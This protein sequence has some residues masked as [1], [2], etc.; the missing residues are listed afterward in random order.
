MACSS[1]GGNSSNKRSVVNT[2]TTNRTALIDLIPQE[3]Q[4]K[5]VYIGGSYTHKIVSPN[6]AIYPLGYTNYG[7]GRGGDVLIIHKDDF[8]VLPSTYR[9][10][11]ELYEQPEA[12]QQMTVERKQVNVTEVKEPV[13]T[14]NL[15]T[16]NESEDVSKDDESLDTEP[17]TEKVVVKNEKP[18]SSK[19]NLFD[20][21][22][23]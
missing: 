6:G 8:P 12:Q 5:V 10:Y 18:K 7:M 2:T 11:F 20:E 1:C 22:K 13:V 14:V 4:L 17:Q 9:K 23:G 19:K 21:L 16:V 3:D 15:D